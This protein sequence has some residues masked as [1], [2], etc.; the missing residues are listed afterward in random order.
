MSEMFILNIT[1]RE[2][3]RDVC[4]S[5][6]GRGEYVATRADFDLP[7]EQFWIW[8]RLKRDNHPIRRIDAGDM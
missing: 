6:A 5:R 4:A 3:T 1:V 8:P 2:H 7:D